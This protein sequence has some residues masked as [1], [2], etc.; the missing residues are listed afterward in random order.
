MQSDQ[1]PS[2]EVVILGGTFDPFHLGHRAILAQ[3]ME[4]LR[5][6]EGW[7]IPLHSPG[8]RHTPVASPEDRLAMAALGVRGLSGVEVRDSEIRRGGVTYTVDTAQEIAH[9]SAAP[10]QWYIVGA[11]EARTLHEWHAWPKLLAYARLAIVNRTGKAPISLEECAAQGIPSSRMAILTVD[12]PPVSATA[13]R[14]ALSDRGQDQF[15]MKF[16]DQA[17]LSYIREHHLYEKSG[18]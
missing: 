6:P 11:D 9:S 17:V 7:V 2:R 15:V 12:S 8:H 18:T 1:T 13:L 16:L 10:D 5:I 4:Q 3:V 14:I